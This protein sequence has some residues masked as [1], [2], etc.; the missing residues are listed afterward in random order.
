[1]KFLKTLK[2]F[3]SPGGIEG[4][5]AAKYAEMAKNTPKIREEYRRLADK[6]AS[7]VQEGRLLEIGPGPG[8]ISIE[9]AKL[10]PEMEIIGLDI[11]DTMIEIAEKNAYEDGLSER[12]VFKKG[13]ASKIPFEDSWFDFVISSGSLHHWKKPIQVFNEIYRV[14]KQGCRALI[15]DLR[16]DAPQEKIKEME[17]LIDSKIMRWGLRHS[18]KESYTAQQIEEIIK[19]TWFT[20]FEIKVEKEEECTL[21]IWLKYVARPP[22]VKVLKILEPMCRGHFNCSTNE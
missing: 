11:S 1:M 18:F 21:E 20:E 9:I 14:L 17:N 7:I 19:N 5:F 8:Y 6:T 4:Y 15:F 16:K 3:V 2:Q 12:I 10:L 13:D 22:G